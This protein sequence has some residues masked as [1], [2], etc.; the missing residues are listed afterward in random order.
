MKDEIKTI[1]EFIKA[2]A[3]NSDRTHERFHIS[4]FLQGLAK[5]ANRT[6]ACI[7]VKSLITNWTVCHFYKYTF[8]FRFCTKKTLTNNSTLI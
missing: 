6:E 3:S 4:E 8:M 2:A 1:A 5:F 7:E